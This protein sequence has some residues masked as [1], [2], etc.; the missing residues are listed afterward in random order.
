MNKYI[1]I[2]FLFLLL[3]CQKEGIVSFDQKKD[4][5]QFNYDPQENQMVLEYDFAFQSVVGKDE[6]GYPTN[7]YLG[8]SISR[9]T[10]SVF[11]SLMG[12]ASD[13]DREFKLKTVPLE[14]LEELPLA[15]VEFLPK[16][17]FRAN[18]LLDTVQVVLIRPER[19]GKYA[20][21]ITFDFEDASSLFDSGAEEQSVYQVM[22]SDRYEKPA[23]WAEGE[24]ALGEFSEEKYAFFVTILGVKFSPYLD[25][26]TYN[27]VLRDKLAEFN[28]KHPDA[29][30]DFSFPVWTKPNWWDWYMGAGT[31]LGEFPEAKKE[32]VISVVGEENYTSYTDWAS[33]M[34]KLREAYDAY[35]EK[36][37][38]EPLP[39]APFPPDPEVS[40]NDK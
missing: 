27:Q 9:D 13:V 7:I 29:P 22:V 37:P 31:Y 10:I 12:H 15:T 25:W 34:P 16:Y 17:T 8:D 6:R 21:G 32:F 26:G 19:R 33:F 38:D 30:K 5:I 28:E 18:R 39:F 36:H 4:C 14:L 35:N 3:G 11:L 20:V 2:G 24:N 1:Y 40:D 23:D